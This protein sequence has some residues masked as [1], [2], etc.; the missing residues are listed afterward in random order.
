MAG[1]CVMIGFLGQ[2][3]IAFHVLYSLLGIADTVLNDMSPG[4]L[5]AF[6]VSQLE[7]DLLPV[8]LAWSQICG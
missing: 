2:C 3:W 8:F 4:F 5:S 7:G 6:C 1:D